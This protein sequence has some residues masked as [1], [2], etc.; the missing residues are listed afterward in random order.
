[1]AIKLRWAMLKSRTKPH[2]YVVEIAH[3]TGLVLTYTNYYQLIY[4]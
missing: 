2:F 1:M 4:D 3:P